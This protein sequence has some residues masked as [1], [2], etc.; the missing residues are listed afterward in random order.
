MAVE[1]QGRRAGGAQC[2]DEG[3]LAAY[4]ATLKSEVGQISQVRGDIADDRLKLIRSFGDRFEAHQITSQ[5]DQLVAESG[6]HTGLLRV[7]LL[8]R[9]PSSIPRL[10]AKERDCDAGKLMLQLTS[11]KLFYRVGGSSLYRT[12]GE[13]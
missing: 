13:L 7:L 11:V 9:A 6:G 2:D 10:C 1:H 3:M 4:R 12:G 8:G 5:R